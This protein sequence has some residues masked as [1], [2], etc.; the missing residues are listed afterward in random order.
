[1]LPLSSDSA[2]PVLGFPLTLANTCP[3]DLS[4]TNSQLQEVPLEDTAA[5]TAFIQAACGGKIGF[6]GYGEHRAVYQRSS[7]FATADQDFRDIHMGV[8]LW[9]EAGSPIFAP[10]EGY[11]HSFQDNAGFGNYGPTLLLAHPMG[12]KTLYSLY[13]HLALEDLQQ[14]TV[15]AAIAKGQR[16]GTI[17]PYPE[18]GDWPPHLHFQLMWDLL[19]HVG[20]F[21]GVCARKDWPRFAANGPDPN[22]LLGFPGAGT[23]D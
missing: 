21:P 2:F 19:G 20:D 6:G 3:L 8:D 22:L 17:G 15:G 23:A 4:P 12:E 1:M 16:I 11:I 10:L 18:N 9:T 5:F 13:G 14:Y 7:V